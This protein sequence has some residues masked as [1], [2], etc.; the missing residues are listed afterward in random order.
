[1]QNTR[2]F[3]ISSF[4][5]YLRGNVTGA[6]LVTRKHR[7]SDDIFLEDLEQSSCQ[8]V[9]REFLGSQSVTQG[10]Y[11]DREGK[12]RVWEEFRIRFKSPVHFQERQVIPKGKYRIRVQTEFGKPVVKTFVRRSL[13]FIIW[14]KEEKL[15]PSLP[16]DRILNGRLEDYAL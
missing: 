5:D 10:D 2:Y 6:S 13:G 9:D 3:N 11:Y 8:F 15:P 4:N 14:W 7:D 16:L 12:R 1:M